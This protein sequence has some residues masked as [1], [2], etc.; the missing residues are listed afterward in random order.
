MCFGLR[1]D[2]VKGPEDRDNITRQHSVRA[3]KPPSHLPREGGRAL[4][5]AVGGSSNRWTRRDTVR[6]LSLRIGAGCLPAVYRFLM[7]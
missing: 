5:D 6:K 7:R 1:I 2:M 4:A 3:G